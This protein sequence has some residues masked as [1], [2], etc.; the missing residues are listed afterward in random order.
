[1]HSL[2][3]LQLLLHLEEIILLLITLK[4]IPVRSV[5]FAI[6]QYTSITLKLHSDSFTSY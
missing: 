6:F 3:L 2:Y 1:M 5:L 4:I